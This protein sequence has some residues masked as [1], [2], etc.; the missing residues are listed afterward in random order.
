MATERDLFAGFERMRREM[1]ELLGAGGRA[2]R[3]A[4]FTPRV[5]VAYAADP[6]RAIVTVELAGVRAEDFELE[7]RGRE[8]VLSGHR[9]PLEQTEGRV[10]QQVEIEYGPFRRVVALGADVDAE[11]VTA[12]LHEGVLRVEVPL[13]QPESTRR[14]VPIEVRER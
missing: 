10:F 12:R 9:G 8:L 4:A 5:D 11:R 13:R 7:V 1:D 3:R 14:S 6:P 2:L